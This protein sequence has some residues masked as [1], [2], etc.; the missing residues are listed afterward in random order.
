MTVPNLPAAGGTLRDI[1]PTIAR[2]PYTGSWWLQSMVTG[3]PDSALGWLVGQGWQLTGSSTDEDG[4]TTHTM[5]RQSM[6]SWLILQSLLNQFV[7]SYNEGRAA[8]SIRYNDVV[9]RWANLINVTRSTLNMHANISDGHVS[10]Y[11]GYLDTLVTEV[12]TQMAVVESDMTVASGRVVGQFADYLTRL[13][14]I[15]SQYDAHVTTIGLLLSQLETDMETFVANYAAAVDRLEAAMTTHRAAVDAIKTESTSALA[16]HDT[17][18]TSLTTTVQNDYTA[19]LATIQILLA[20]LTT[21]LGTHIATITSSLNDSL[22][23]YTSLDDEINALLTTLDNEFGA[24]SADADSIFALLLSDYTT[25]AALARG[26]LTNLGTTETARINEQFSNLTAKLMQEMMNRGLYSSGLFAPIQTRVERERS[27]ALSKLN[28]QL[29]REKLDNQHKLY[30]QQLDVRTR[31]L[32]GKT[33][34]FGVQQDVIRYNAETL[35]R[36]YAQLQELRVRTASSQDQ[37]FDLRRQ[38][39]Q[40]NI[41]TRD[42]LFGQKTNV[43][44]L[45]M[46]AEDRLYQYGEA[47]RKL[48]H[49]DEHQIFTELSAVLGRDLESV[50]KSYEAQRA[51]SDATL[52]QR[53]HLLSQFIESRGRVLGGQEKYAAMALQNGQFLTETR[54]RMVATIMQARMARA[55]GK[56]DV[57]DKEEKIMAYQLDTYNNLAI[58]LFGFVEKRTDEY[59]D[60]AEITKLV[61]GLGDSGGGWVVP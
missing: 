33:R 9:D 46:E 56:M 22:S 2:S 19:H 11:L 54:Q 61:A 35:S 53:D 4:V 41:A 60:M 10:V 43:Q 49:G 42:S 50:I 36:L 17:V 45:L 34:V 25:H 7:S 47:I 32:D 30:G 6:N 14:T 16:D 18:Y 31:T 58:G 24:Y 23:D 15:E 26:F 13:A 57:R 21:Q 29:N 40:F 44:K 27:E 37:L 38:V 51:I 3:V 55:A 28:D 48:R 12:D 52:K 5:T 39:A 20:D 1:S 59:P 8:N